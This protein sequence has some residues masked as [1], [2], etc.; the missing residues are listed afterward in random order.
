[1]KMMFGLVAPAAVLI[2]TTIAAVAAHRMLRK[3]F[4][5]LPI[6]NIG[7]RARPIRIKR[8]S[9]P[10]IAY[11]AGGK[12]RLKVD[13]AEPR[14]VPSQ[15]GNTIRERS[16]KAQQ[17]HAWKSEG[18]N[19]FLS[20]SVLWGRA[21]CAPSAIRIVTTSLCRGTSAGQFLY[22]LETDNSCGLLA[23]DN[24][25]AEE[26]RLWSNNTRRLRYISTYRGH[27]AC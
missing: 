23:V 6:L 21:D 11:L 3:N 10:P 13:G 8:M 4:I 20:G 24:L 27:V 7:P 18:G 26:R 17:R 1:M 19:S 14:T 2:D 16:V 22:A 9:T 5:I 25:G 15:Y 12:I